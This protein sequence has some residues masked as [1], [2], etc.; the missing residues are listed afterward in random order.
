MEH[1]FYIHLKSS[2]YV[3]MHT[4]IPYDLYVLYLI[5]VIIVKSNFHYMIRKLDV[6]EF[7]TLVQGHLAWYVVELRSEHRTLYIILSLLGIDL[8]SILSNISMVTPAL[9]VT[10]CMKYPFPSFHFQSI[11]CLFGSKV[12]LL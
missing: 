7:K 4:Y 5:L 11:C 3:H 6:S 8:N 12:S 9:L 10:I 2:M 1:K